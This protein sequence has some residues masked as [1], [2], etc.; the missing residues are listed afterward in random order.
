M[1]KKLKNATQ[2][3]KIV[4]KIENKEGLKNKDQIISSSDAIMID[5]GI[6]QLKQT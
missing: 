3:S 1:L 5:R 6:F 4:A 2:I